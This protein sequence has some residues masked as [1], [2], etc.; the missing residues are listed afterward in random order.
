MITDKIEFQRQLKKHGNPDTVFY[1]PG[2]HF[3]L[4]NWNDNE[5]MF[6]VVSAQLIKTILKNYSNEKGDAMTVFI[7]QPI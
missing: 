1:Y 6:F 7:Y 3:G 5:D 2:N 4:I